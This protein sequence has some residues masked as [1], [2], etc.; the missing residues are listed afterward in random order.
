MYLCKLS[1]QKKSVPLKRLE[2]FGDLMIPQ[3]YETVLFSSWFF[4]VT[5]ISILQ[6]E[7]YKLLV[8]N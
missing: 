6:V 4:V 2:N 3:F 1:V 7:A 8:L 5:E